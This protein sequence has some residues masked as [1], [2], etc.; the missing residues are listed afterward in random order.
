MPD[1]ASGARILPTFL[2]KSAIMPK[3]HQTPVLFAVAGTLLMQPSAHAGHQG[4]DGHWTFGGFGTLSAVHSSEKQADFSA[5]PLNPGNAG[6]SHDWSYG[7]DS[8]VGSQLA[9]NGGH[10]SAVLQVV[11]VM[12]PNST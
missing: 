5:N 8:R 3:L 12:P 6:A 10:W 2:A 11:A 9:Y 4:Q 1:T 7:V